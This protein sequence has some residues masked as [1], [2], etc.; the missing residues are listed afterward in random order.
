[1]VIINKHESH[2]IKYSED[3]VR[4]A[5][6]EQKDFQAIFSSTHNCL[7]APLNESLLRDFAAKLVH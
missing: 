6:D 2:I 5:N 1:M 7:K 3:L 4:V